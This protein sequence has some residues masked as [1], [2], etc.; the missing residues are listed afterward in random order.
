MWMPRN[1]WREIDV[2]LPSLWMDMYE[3]TIGQYLECVEAGVC[4]IKSL[5]VYPALS[6]AISHPEGKDRPAIASYWD[7]AKYCAWRGKRLPTE[8]EWERAARGPARFDY[9]WGNALPSQQ[10]M[11]TRTA[12]DPYRFSPENAPPPVGTNPEDVS[13]EGVHDLFASVREW[14]SDWYAPDYEAAEQGA[15]PT[16]PK[17][18]VFS[19]R[20]NDYGEGNT[21]DA[22]G[23]KVVRGA[24]NLGWFGGRGW[25]ETRRSAALWFRGFATPGTVAT[26]LGFRCVRDDKPALSFSAAE[27]TTPPPVYRGILWRPLGQGPASGGVR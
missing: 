2:Q 8:A 9:P 17:R 11:S 13:S 21:L 1:D 22:H 19:S 5:R 20:P 15:P 6:A 24:R 10:I 18:P 23:E 12:Y 26:D 7:A 3:T 27:T 25:Q 14:T 16:G 4:G